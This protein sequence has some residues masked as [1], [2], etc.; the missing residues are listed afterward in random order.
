MRTLE[1]LFTPAEFAGLHQRDLSETVCVV[2]DVLR[3]SS[4]MVT[5]LVNGAAGIIPVGEIAEA[6]AIRRWEPEAVLA[7][8]RDGLRIQPE[9]SGGVA[10]DLGN[11]PREFTRDKVGGKTIV[12]TTTN[13]T[14]ALR[15]CAQARR[16]L[17]GSFLN[18]GATADLLKEDPPKRLLVVCSG[19]LEQAAFEDALAAGALCD[20]IWPQYRSGAVADSA[21]MAQRLFH[22]EEKD[23][24]AA[25]AQSRNGQRLL[26]RPELEADVA[27]CAQR[28]VFP[29]VAELGPD[30]FVRRRD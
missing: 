6:L 23:L 21:G 11:S 27:F 12:M 9:R 15:A 22:A 25:V 14:R 3:A 13:G 18:L 26:G 5:A 24:L 8:E 10:F 20:S 28:D 29:L 4:T 19:T 7:G 17:V 16:V 1:V 2:F 30:G